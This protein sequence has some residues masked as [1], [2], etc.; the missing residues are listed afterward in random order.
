MRFYGIKE[1]NQQKDLPKNVKYRP[2]GN[3]LHEPENEIC[4]NINEMSLI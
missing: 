1:E 4:Q 2:L 3:N